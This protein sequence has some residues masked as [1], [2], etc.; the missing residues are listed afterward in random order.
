[1]SLNIILI[2]RGFVCEISSAVS[3]SQNILQCPTA[4]DTKSLE[5]PI[6]RQLKY[7]VKIAFSKTNGSTGAK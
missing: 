2:D 3:F 4:L 5:P 6:L 7:N 1:M